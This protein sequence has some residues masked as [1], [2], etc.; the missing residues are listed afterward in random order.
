MDGGDAISNH[1]VMS[2][3][4]RC[5]ALLRNGQPC[6]RTVAQGSE[7]CV[8]HTK[9]LATVDAETLRSG[10]M[11]K[12]RSAAKQ[13]LHLV[14]EPRSDAEMTVTA[15][16]AT[17]DPATVRP[18]L[19]AA[20]AENLEQLTTSLLEAAGSAA[21]PVWITVACNNCGVRSQVEAPVPDVRARLAANRAPAPRRIGPST[22]GR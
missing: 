18:S 4:P 6:N 20:A 1:S 7:F 2:A 17:A 19:A 14:S 10:R 11:P 12:T 9:L 16:I 21:K 15:T 8:H 13:M 22:A 3:L 5:A